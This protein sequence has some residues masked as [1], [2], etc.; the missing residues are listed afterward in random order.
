VHTGQHR[1]GRVQEEWEE[2]EEEKE[3][4]EEEEGFIDKQRMNAGR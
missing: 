4:E 3:E 1:G 2:K